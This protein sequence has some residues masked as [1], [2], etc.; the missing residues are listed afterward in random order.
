MPRNLFADSRS[1]EALFFEMFGPSAEVRAVIGPSGEGVEFREWA[2]P[3]RRPAPPRPTATRP[4]EVPGE[5]EL[6]TAE[7]VAEMMKGAR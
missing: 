2:E 5:P 7:Q 1:G 6:L 3:A 4:G